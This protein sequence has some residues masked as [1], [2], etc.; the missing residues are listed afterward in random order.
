MRM[1]PLA[2]AGC[3]SLGACGFTAE[4][5]PS[6]IDAPLDSAPDIDAA[7]IVPLLV[8]EQTQFATTGAQLTVTFGNT[9]AAGNT[10]VMIGAANSGSLTA[11]TGGGVATWTRAASAASNANIE[12]WFGVTDGSQGVISISRTGNPLAIWLSV[13]EWSGLATS[14]SLDTAVAASG[15]STTA[16]AGTI[17]TTNPRDLVIFAV[18][19]ENAGAFGNPTQGPWSPFAVLSGNSIR[20]T[21][22]HRVVSATGSY[23]PEVPTSG[24]DWD[25][26]L[27]ALRIAP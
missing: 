11:V 26:A 12:V 24:A 10:L 22:W 5:A 27:V 3:A 16:S 9:P 17:T 25:A 21:A 1:L 8:Q 19:D 4:R 20:Q 23:T 2:L 6:Q 7:A 15:T 18:A 13:T 14:T